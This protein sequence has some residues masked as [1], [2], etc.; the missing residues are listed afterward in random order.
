M[1]L[2]NNL[3][4]ESAESGQAVRGQAG[5]G[6]NGV[7]SSGQ[8]EDSNVDLT[9]ELVQLIIMQRNYQANAQ[10]IRTQDQLLQT[11]TNLR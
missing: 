2:G 7:I 3:W 8:V 11:V 6:L 1:S 5:T 9:Q 10:T 4:A